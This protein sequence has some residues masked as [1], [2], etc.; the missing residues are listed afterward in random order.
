MSGS[1]Y[2]EIEETQCPKQG[3]SSCKSTKSKDLSS[4]LPNSTKSLTLEK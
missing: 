1:A 4:W 3:K 2:G